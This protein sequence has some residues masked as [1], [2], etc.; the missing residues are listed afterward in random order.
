M[1]EAAFPHCSSSVWSSRPWRRKAG[2]REAVK[3]TGWEQHPQDRLEMGSEV[4]DWGLGPCPPDH[5]T[6]EREDNKSNSTH[7][8]NK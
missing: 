2:L 3:V 5:W 7:I 1:N 8:P 4:P 6:L